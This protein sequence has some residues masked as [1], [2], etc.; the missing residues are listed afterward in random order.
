MLKNKT[1]I[2]CIFTATLLPLAQPVAAFQDNTDNAVNLLELSLAELI[3]TP[4]I[5]A[6][7]SAENRDQTPAHIMVITRDQIRERRY[8]NLADLLEDMPGVDFQRGTKSSQFNQFTVQGNLGPNRLLVL[9]DGIRISQ[10]SAGNYPIAENIALYQAKQVEFLYGPA[11]ALYGADAVSGVVNIITEAGNQTDGSWIS[12]GGGNFNSREHSM[13]AGFNGDNDVSFSIGAHWQESDRARLD[14]LYKSDFNK[15]D[16]DG[17]IIKASQRERYR[18]E[19]SSHSLFARLDVAE[20]FTFGY[21]RHHYTSLTS[22]GDPYF[23]T[24]YSDKARWMTTSD[25]FY[26]RYRFALT[27]NLNGQLRLD[28]SRMEVDPRSHYNN[29]YNQF[30]P[31][32][33]YSYGHRI[34]AEQSFDWQWTEQQQVKLGLGAQRFKAIEGGSMP[35]K[36]STGSSPGD[37][38]MLYPNTNLPMQ[39][40]HDR[41]RSYYVYT[42]LQSQ[43]SDQVSTSAGFRFDHHSAYGDTVNPRLG[44]VWHPL[45]KH[46]FKIL[47]GEAFRAPSAE[48]S[49]SGYGS[50]EKPTSSAPSAPPV[51]HGF[52]I[53]NPDLRPEKVRT[54]SLVWEWRP[55][56]NLNLISNLYHSRITDLIVT[57]EHS[58]NNTSAIPG[59]VLTKAS[60]KINAGRQKQTGLDLSA[61][62]RYRLTDNWAGDL[63]ASAGWL[64]GR[65]SDANG[66]DWELPYVARYRFK[67]G[68]TLRYRDNLTL[69]SKLRWT[70]D[71][72]SSRTKQPSTKENLPSAHC[73]GTKKAPDRCTTKGYAVLDMHLGWQNLLDDRVSLWLDVYNVTDKRYYAA[74]GAAS[75]TFWDMP[76]QPRTW[77][78]STEWRF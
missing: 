42:Q 35:H 2:A 27:E 45:D 48:E 20:A 19:T 18:G 12:I 23:T 30:E 37:Q 66:V 44:L 51:G 59:A 38:D 74:G 47:Y 77:V 43:W 53:A 24:R 31:R 76:Q 39:I 41:N 6:S 22:T 14:K 73:K 40:A 62:W 57:G 61:Q 10:P 65:V 4:V 63:W 49:L 9:L 69:T 78:V 67:A 50:F 11:A 36:Y 71:V 68:T 58:T 54:L 34:G 17:A 72:T 70:G 46:L 5:T 21:Y 56:R 26:G 29:R 32:Y 25:T 8:K 55:T 15:V 7:R 16:S 52:R 60:Q 13:M 3:N 28:Y 75:Y 64:H 33:S 1:P